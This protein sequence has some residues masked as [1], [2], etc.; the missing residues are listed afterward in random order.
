MWQADKSPQAQSRL[1][2]LK[3]LVRFMHEFD[4]PHGF[5]EH[6]ESRDGRRPGR[7]R[8]A[9]VADDAARGQRVSSSRSCSCPAG[10]RGSFR[11][12]ASLDESG[13]AG[14]EEERRLA[15]VG[16]HAR[17]SASPRFRSRRTAATAGSTSRRCRRAS[18]TSFRRRTSRCWRQ[19]CRS[20]ARTRTSAAVQAQPLRRT[21]R[22]STATYD[23]PG[24]QRAQERA[25][26]VRGGV[27]PG[28]R[29]ASR[30][31]R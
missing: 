15:Y 6:V 5:L 19:R 23:T 22:R 16:T 7:R 11:T 1:E 17:Q 29:R 12:S 20:A 10:R 2:N 8:R 13:Q 26:S 30:A 27:E 21:P 4:S 24:W 14:L 3:E 31:G 25:R 28:R 9:R 18:S